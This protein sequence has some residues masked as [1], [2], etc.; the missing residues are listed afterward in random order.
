M[1]QI[2]IRQAEP[3]DIPFLTKLDHFFETTYVW[4]MERNQDIGEINLGFRKVRLPRSVRVDYPRPPEVLEQD[5]R[6][7]TVVLAASLNHDL[8]GYISLL[9]QPATQSAWITDL[10]VHYDLRRKGIGTA[11]VISAHEWAA[12]HRLRWMTMEMQSKNYPA[13][14]LASKLGY[15]FCGF[16]EHYYANQDIVLFFGSYIR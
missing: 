2:E 8:V 5:L 16:N 1:P 7:K 13:I 11:L 6:H 14:C 12:R 9:E 15:E 4:Q 3:E 10:A